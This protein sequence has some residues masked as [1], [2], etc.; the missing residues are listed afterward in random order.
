MLPA[1]RLHATEAFS[2]CGLF[3]SLPSTVNVK[4]VTMLIRSTSSVDG[5]NRILLTTFDLLCLNATEDFSNCG[6]FRSLPLT[7]KHQ[8]RD[9]LIRHLSSVD[10]CLR[11][12]AAQSVS[13]IYIA[14]NYA[15]VA[16]LQQRYDNGVVLSK[17]EQDMHYDSDLRFVVGTPA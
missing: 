14:D 10:G 12:I 11:R 4:R 3:R 5:C 9:L 16:C 15:A 1:Q 6:L 8:T 7:V 17:L 13:V 2:N